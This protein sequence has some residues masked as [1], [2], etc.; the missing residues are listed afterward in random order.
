MS[1]KGKKFTDDGWAFWVDGDDTS[2]I[3][4]QD[5]MN[6]KGKSF[7]DVSVKIIGIKDTKKL[8]LSR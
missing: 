8:S 2:T 4:F 7:I 3:Y 5:W 1:V 6:P